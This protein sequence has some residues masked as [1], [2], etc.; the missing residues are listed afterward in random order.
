[1]PDVIETATRSYPFRVSPI[2]IIVLSHAVMIVERLFDHWDGPQRRRACPLGSRL[3]IARS[4]AQTTSAVQIHA[5]ERGSKKS[6][7]SDAIPI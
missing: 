4:Q 3:R 6:R 5:Q 7:P 2:T 1:M